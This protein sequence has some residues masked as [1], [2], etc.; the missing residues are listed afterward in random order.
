MQGVPGAECAMHHCLPCFLCCRSCGASIPMVRNLK[1][2]S[3]IPEKKQQGVP[4][5][6][7]RRISKT[8]RNNVEINERTRVRRQLLIRIGKCLSFLRARVV[9]S[10]LVV[11]SS[12]SDGLRCAWCCRKRT[13]TSRTRWTKCDTSP[14]SCARLLAVSDRPSFWL[15]GSLHFLANNGRGSAHA[16]GRTSVCLCAILTHRG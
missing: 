1:S 12:G 4:N 16:T 9:D 5:L 2:L 3:H 13:T 10:F 11:N 6:Q 15:H 14:I 8:G 7:Q